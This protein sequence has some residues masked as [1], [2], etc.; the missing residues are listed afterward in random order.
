ML[1]MGAAIGLFV[2]ALG[3]ASWFEGL[4]DAARIRA[5][6]DAQVA[7]QKADYEYGKEGGDEA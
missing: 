5:K 2:V 7:L 3:L 4:G 1:E 6:A